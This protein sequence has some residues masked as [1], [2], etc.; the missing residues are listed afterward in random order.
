MERRSEPRE[1]VSRPARF[2]TLT[3]VALT[4][5]AEMTSVSGRGA[6]FRLGQELEPGGLV[7]ADLDDIVLLGEVVY[8]ERDGDV[9]RCGLRLEHSVSFSADL[10]RLGD[11]LLTSTMAPAVTSQS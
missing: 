3:G 2:T 4:C 11:S 5:L 1:L 9:W 6:S 8:C 7:R 10:R